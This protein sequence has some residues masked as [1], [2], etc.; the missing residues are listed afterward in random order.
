MGGRP[1]THRHPIFRSA[2]GGSVEKAEGLLAV[3]KAP[4]V[5]TG[6]SQ[7]PVAGSAVRPGAER[8]RCLLAWTT[9]RH[10]NGIKMDEPQKAVRLDKGWT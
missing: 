7:A 5:V 10:S 3:E 6:E 4:G 2:L 8:D 1:L 9:R